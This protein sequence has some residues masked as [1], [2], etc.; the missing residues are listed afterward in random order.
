MLYI[1]CFEAKLWASFYFR[2]CLQIL[3]KFG[4]IYVAYLASFSAENIKQ[5]N[6][7]WYFQGKEELN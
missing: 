4:L 7:F 3:V 6:T 2:A 5:T 1:L